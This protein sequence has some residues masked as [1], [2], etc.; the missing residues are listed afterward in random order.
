MNYG[1]KLT[2]ELTNSDCQKL[3]AAVF[4]SLCLGIRFTIFISIHLEKAG[5]TP[6]Y[7]PFISA[8]IKHIG[9]FIY[10][11]TCKPPHWIYVLESTTGRNLHILV[12]VPHSLIPRF[13]RLCRRP[14]VEESGGA[15]H[16]KVVLPLVIKCSSP[17][18]LLTDYICF[19]L[20]GTFKYFLKGAEPTICDWIGRPHEDQGIII[21]TRCRTSQSLGRKARD[22]HGPLRNDNKIR[23]ILDEALLR[24]DLP[25]VSSGTKAEPTQKSAPTRRLTRGAPT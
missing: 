18:D 9:D 23:A 14:W 11:N 1:N 20:K 10:T 25:P 16:K 3:N 22:E 12:N 21:G 24:L 19:G 13:R 5:V 15:Y 8:Y 7:R 4:F 17:D 2:R 6:D